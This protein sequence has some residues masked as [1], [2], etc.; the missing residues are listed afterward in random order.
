[1]F[2]LV[3]MMSNVD[4]VQPVACALGEFMSGFDEICSGGVESSHSVLQ[5]VLLL[6]VKSVL[7]EKVIHFCVSDPAF[8]DNS[9][10]LLKRLGFTVVPAPNLDEDEN[11]VC[12]FFPKQIH[13]PAPTEDAIILKLLN[14]IAKTPSAVREA[15]SSSAHQSTANS[16]ANS[17]ESC[18][19]FVFSLNQT[20]WNSFLERLD[21]VLNLGKTVFIV[22]S[23]NFLD[24]IEPV[25]Y[26]IV[27]LAAHKLSDKNNAFQNYKLFKV[28]K[29]DQLLKPTVSNTDQL[30]A[31]EVKR[32][33]EDGK[34]LV[35]RIEAECRP[36]EIKIEANHLHN[37]VQIWANTESLNAW[38][39]VK[40]QFMA[41]IPLPNNA[42]CAEISSAVSPTGVLK[43]IIPKNQTD[44]D[45]LSIFGSDLSQEDEK[46]LVTNDVKVLSNMKMTTFVIEI[47]HFELKEITIASKANVLE[48]SANREHGSDKW[49]VKRWFL[50]RIQL[51]DVLQQETISYT[52]DRPGILKI[53]LPKNS[54]IADKPVII[55]HTG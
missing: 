15:H 20:A 21:S 38:S 48:I 8:G 9:K 26:V 47:E 42:N 50:A 29:A 2:A 30:L 27:E 5:L 39:F 18:L 55:Q 6:Q 43:I 53:T 28:S 22:S 33:K 37:L 51:K 52:M 11:I 45:Q 12:K 25:G 3:Q 24:K 41:K 17:P 54:E 13:D 10:Q 46:Q 1:M 35:L 4:S 23:R 34:H 7:K 36:D 31:R 16:P 32:Q 19:I 49:F 14:F 40:R 44:A